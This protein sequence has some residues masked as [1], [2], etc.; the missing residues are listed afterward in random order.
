MIPRGLI[1]T[2][3]LPLLLVTSPALAQGVHGVFTVVKGDVQVESGKDKKVQKARIGAKVF[4]SDTIIAGKDSR[5]KIEM[6]D[7]NIINIS[8]DSKLLIEKY[9]NSGG[10][11]EVLL[12]VLQGKV[13]PAVNQK[14]DGESE[15]FHVKTPSAVA[16]VRGTDFL[17]SYN[18]G[19]KAS[20]V[21]TF[22]GKVDVGAKVDVSGKIVNPVSV[23]PGQFTTSS[24][25]APPAP[26]APMPQEQLKQMNRESVAE[27]SAN[28][29]GPAG[30]P[31]AASGDKNSDDGGKDKKDAPADSKNA[32]GPGDKPSDKSGSDS[33]G[34]DNAAG[35]QDKGPNARADAPNDSA[36][37][38]EKKAPPGGGDK[39]AGGPKGPGPGAPPALDAPGD[40]PKPEGGRSPSSAGG[41]PAMGTPPPMMAPT[42][43]DLTNTAPD[44]AG[45]RLPTGMIQPGMPIQP[46]LPP[47]I[48]F[49]NPDIIQNNGNSRVLIRISSPSN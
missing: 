45:P 10:K 33:S 39:A 8:P 9:E 31:T 11:K 1:G 2:F 32:G 49:V 25:S 29:A 37:S 4:A 47:P 41:G 27:P 30:S 26:P 18:P 3:F 16:G 23:L 7:K 19:T 20:Q 14:Y 5:A 44:L 46:M 15:K 22:E 35:G 28:A 48:Q 13:R 42:A 21:V 36:G 24:A 12:N 6:S 40:G 43:G 17:V 38:D 34:G